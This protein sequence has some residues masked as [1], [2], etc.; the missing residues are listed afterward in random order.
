MRDRP[1]SDDLSGFRW[2]TGAPLRRLTKEEPCPVLFR[3]LGPRATAMFLRG[4]LKRLAGPLSPITY[5][6]SAEYCE[7]YTDFE[8]IGRVV[9][10]RPGRLGVWHSGIEHVYVAP[11]CPGVD[12]QTVG[13]VPCHLELGEAARL[14][15][16]V[17]DTSEW[18]EALGGQAHDEAASESLLR[19]DRLERELAESEELAD[20]LRKSAQSPDRRKRESAREAMARAG[21]TESDLCTA[22]HHLPRERRGFI[23]E[24]LRGLAVGGERG[25]A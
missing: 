23:V 20:P 13:F 15:A 19:L 24:A 25:A 11:A 21:L 10:F 3:D 12:A 9:M 7:P 14:A 6:R 8:G 16:G 22:W 1:D 4:R 17:A 2:H 5:T 18:R